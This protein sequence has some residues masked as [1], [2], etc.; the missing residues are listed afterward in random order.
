MHQTQFSEKN[1]IRRVFPNPV[2][3][4][5]NKPLLN[6]VNFK[7]RFEEDGILKWYEGHTSSSYRGWLYN[8]H[9]H[10]TDKNCQF[11]VEDFYS[12]DFC[13]MQYS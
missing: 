10:E 8:L 2:T 5:F 4:I 6:R 11:L 13:I 12:G 1:P 9:Y 3:I 7:H